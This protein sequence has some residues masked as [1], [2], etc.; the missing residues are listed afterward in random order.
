MSSLDRGN[1]VCK[2]PEVGKRLMS[3]RTGKT[4]SELEEASEK[5]GV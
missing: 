5:R 3:L 1:N 4:T 2:G